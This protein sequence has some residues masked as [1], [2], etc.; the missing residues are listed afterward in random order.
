MKKNKLIEKKLNMLAQS[1]HLDRDIIR[2]AEAE[3][4]RFEKQPAKAPFSR[5]K[6]WIA[7][8][9]CAVLVI[10]LITV[11]LLKNNTDKENSP[12]TYQLSSLI[13]AKADGIEYDNA[14][15]ISVDNAELVQKT[16]SYADN[17]DVQVVATSIVSVTEHG[18]DKILIY[19]DRGSGLLDFA[20]FK[21]YPER[22]ISGITV[23]FYTEYKD[24]E[25]LSYCYF[26]ADGY[27]YYIVIMSP[28]GSAAEYYFGKN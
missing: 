3:L 17:G 14:V 16:Y 12:S 2:D 15:P 4:C 13:S 22:V 27:D 20:F 28:D 9:C 5:K 7:A 21:K 26:S 8:S 19:E 11:F 1:A 10:S 25:Y 6:L 24:G 23:R 18:T